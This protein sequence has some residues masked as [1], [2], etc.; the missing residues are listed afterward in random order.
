MPN[1]MQDWIKE[2]QLNEKR[3]VEKYPFLRARDIDG[4]IDTDSAFPMI[5]LEIPNGWYRLFFQ[6]CEDI[7]PLVSEDFYFIQVKEK[8]NRL[9]CYPVNS[10]TKVDMILAKYYQIAPY[11]CIHCGRPATY[12]TKD[13]IAS[14]CEDCWK[15]WMRHK[16]V[17]LLKFKPYFIINSETENVHYD[18]KHI[19][20]KDEWDKYLNS[21][22]SKGEH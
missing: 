18:E 1:E 5:G 16:R 4:S 14:F 19:S 17:D 21:I 15:G 8:Y 9:V 20:F 12:E 11:V 7:K 22:E 10:N 13:Y 2:R 3:W 6:M